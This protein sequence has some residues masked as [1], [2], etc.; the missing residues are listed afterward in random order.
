M[1]FPDIRHAGFAF[2]SAPSLESTQASA[3]A[4]LKH[5]NSSLPVHL[6]MDLEHPG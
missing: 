5:A 3:L 4:I 1:H 2:Q 6:A